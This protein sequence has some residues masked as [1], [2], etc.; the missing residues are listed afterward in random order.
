[1]ANNNNQYSLC[2]YFPELPNWALG[3]GL[4]ESKKN[5]QTDDKLNVFVSCYIKFVLKDIKRYFLPISD[6]APC[7]KNFYTSRLLCTPYDY[8]NNLSKKYHDVYDVQFGLTRKIPHK[9]H[10][11]RMVNVRNVLVKKN[12]GGIADYLPVPNMW[13]KTTDQFANKNKNGKN[14]VVIVFDIADIISNIKLRKKLPIAGKHTICNCKNYKQLNILLVGSNE[15]LEYISGYT[16]S[17]LASVSMVGLFKYLQYFEQNKPSV[18]SYN[19]E[20]NRV[21]I[22]DIEQHLGKVNV[23]YTN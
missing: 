7:W 20:L 19:D 3:F 8:N 5:T 22:N 9:V 21:H 4:E 1:M 2:Q 14:V 10:Y 18:F 15:D 13:F 23:H 12:L 6:N 16:G 11:I 17:T